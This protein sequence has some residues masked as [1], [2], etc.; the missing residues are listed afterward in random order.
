MPDIDLSNLDDQYAKVA[1]PEKGEFDEV[2]DG[3]YLTFV[4]KVALKT[5]QAGNAYL[6]WQLRVVGGAN[7]GRCIFR[8]N[9]LQSE[10]NLSY[11]KADLALAGVELSKLSDLPNR[12]GDLLDVRLE[13]RKVTKGEFANVYLQKRLDGKAS[14]EDGTKGKAGEAKPDAK[15]EPEAATAGAAKKKP[16]F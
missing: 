4:E 3:T 10:T 5:S 7:D 13:V 6:N 15:A 11:L 16:K 2:P 1:P 12:L 14:A 9:M 8:K